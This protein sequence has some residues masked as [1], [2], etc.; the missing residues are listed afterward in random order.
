VTPHRASVE[1]GEEAKVARYF[2]RQSVDMDP[3]QLRRS[4][5]VLVGPVH[6]VDCAAGQ[7]LDVVAPRRQLGSE[8]PA[9]ELG[10]SCN[11]PAVTL[12]DEE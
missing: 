4:G 10:A 3:V 2:D 11:L 8:L 7:N 1:R 9:A 12:D 6:I 5:R